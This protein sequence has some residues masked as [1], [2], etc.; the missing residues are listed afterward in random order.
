MPKIH[1]S[2]SLGG[3]VSENSTACGKRGS[4]KVLIVPKTHSSGSLGGHVSG[5][6]TP[7]G[8]PGSATVVSQFQRLARERFTGNW[9]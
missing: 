5:N 7:C 9:I 3:H 2:G 6:P 4:A 8:K 1:S